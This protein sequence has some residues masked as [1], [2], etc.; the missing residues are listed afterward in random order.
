MTLS[1]SI[2][3]SLSRSV[4]I[5][6]LAVGPSAIVI[7]QIHMERGL[8]SR[9]LLLIL[10]MIP[11]FVP[12]LLIG[13]HYRLT[14]TQLSSGESPLVA[15]VCTELLYSVLQ[16]A[17][18]VS[19]GVAV[20]LLF[21]RNEVSD[22]AQYSWSLLRK[23]IPIW[24]WRCGWIKLQLA[25]PWASRLVGW[26]IMAL[27]TFQEFETA[28]LMQIDR[29]PVAWSVWL[30][31]A[32]AARQPL[33]DSLRM[34]MRPALC[35]LVLLTPMLS[36]ITQR[37][38]R[39]AGDVDSP[40]FDARQSDSK[41]SWRKFSG[42]V[43]LIPGISLLLLWP[44]ITNAQ[45][46][47]A[48]L[49][50][51]LTQGSALAQSL[52]QMMTSTAFAA[53]ATVVAVNIAIS[54]VRSWSLRSRGTAILMSLPV[55]PGLMGSLVVSLLL[56]AMFQVPLLRWSYDTWLPMLLGQVLVVLPKT[57]AVVVLL[58]QA[59]DSSA[60]HSAKLL[61]KSDDVRVRTKAVRLLWRM[62]DGRWLIGCLLI[63]H[64]C[65]WDVTVASILRPVQLEPVVTRLYNEMHY[66]RTEALMSLAVLAAFSPV[67]V[68]L[69]A[70]SVSILWSGR[71]RKLRSL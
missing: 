19:V 21:P 51:M 32:H 14:A 20:S 65:F 35:E 4:L 5:A 31:D 2:F 17:R 54:L 53:T 39:A 50:A 48:G 1:E 66:G 55:L 15:A 36:L 45:S 63:A 59:A 28:A 68:W 37:R 49:R 44:L 42:F 22:T 18:C 11:F 40:D 71:L 25:G 67:L 56:L 46:T 10:A 38:F 41:R 64:W 9:R 52:K 24:Q 23:T 33:S 27:M 34:V 12:E 43:W 47:T 60:Q 16:F 61:M 13:F 29:H 62:T 6:S 7:R 70:T 26:S 58:M 69:L 30:F 57:V 3:W 8:G